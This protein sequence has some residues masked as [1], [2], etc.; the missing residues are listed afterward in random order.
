[1]HDAL[2]GAPATEPVLSNLLSD[3]TLGSQRLEVTAGTVLL[4]PDAEPSNVLFIHR[5][6]LRV[7]EVGPDGAGR[8]LDILGAGDWIGASALGQLP[9]VGVRVVA[10]SDAVVSSLPAE[11]MLDALSRY[12]EAAVEVIKQLS[13]KLRRAR[14]D[15]ALLA[16]DDCNRRLI[17]TLLRFSNTAAASPASEG[18]VV[19]RITH[20]QLAQAVGAARETV[21]LALTQLRH[22]NLLRT[23]RNQLRFNPEALRPFAAN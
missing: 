21:S 10:V 1:M 12:P 8:L 5:G 22:Q 19:L 2:A 23:G 16:F 4:E 17:K 3:E 11:R 13:A 7:Y 14:E 15:A 18:N 9:T 20:E 6:E